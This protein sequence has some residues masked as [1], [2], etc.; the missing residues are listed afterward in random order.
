MAHDRLTEQRVTI[1]WLLTKPRSFSNLLAFLDLN[2]RLF[3]VEYKKEGQ[4]WFPC[5]FCVILVFSNFLKIE[6]LG[7]VNSFTLYLWII[8][9]KSRHYLES[10]WKFVF[11]IS[12]KIV[13]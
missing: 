13:S 6:K 2:G 11:S 4:I 7:K 12:F 1:E 3:I 9:T 8:N 5:K 10:I